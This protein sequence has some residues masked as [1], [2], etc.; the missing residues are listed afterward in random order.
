[1]NLFNVV[2]ILILHTVYTNLLLW[3]NGLRHLPTM[4]PWSLKRTWIELHLLS[5]RHSLVISPQIKC[6]ERDLAIN[7]PYIILLKTKCVSDSEE[8]WFCWQPMCNEGR[9]LVN[10][11]WTWVKQNNIKRIFIIE[12]I[13]NY[14][15]YN[16]NLA[17]IEI[18]C[19]CKHNHEQK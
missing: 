10:G 17:G 9:T 3:C 14:W 18:Q 8:H 7:I 11:C 5:L 2:T 16:W 19:K 4:A 12:G 1:M 6:G 15:F 13:S